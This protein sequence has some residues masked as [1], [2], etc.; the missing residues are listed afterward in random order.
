MRK[1]WSVI[2][3]G[4]V[5][6]KAEE[7]M[8]ATWAIRSA[9][10]RLYP[11]V[12]LAS[13]FF[14]PFMERNGVN[15][16]I[17]NRACP[18]EL[19]DLV[20]KGSFSAGEKELLFGIAKRFEGTP[21]AVRS[22][23]QGDSRGTGIYESVF[24][25]NAAKSMEKG[26][27]PA[28]AK[29]VLASAFSHDAYAFRRDA[30]FGEGMAVMVEPVF[31][32]VVED[33]QYIR[34]IRE[35]EDSPP[36]KLAGKYFSPD[37]S[38]VG[39]T[40]TSSGMGHVTVVG[41]LPTMAVRGLGAMLEEGSN[42][43]LTD[44]FYPSYHDLMYL[45][46]TQTEKNWFRGER[47]DLEMERLAVPDIYPDVPPEGGIGWLF[48]KMKKLER[49]LG[50]PQYIEWA[51]LGRTREAAILQIS[52]VAPKKDFFEFPESGD[53]IIRSKQVTGTNIVTCNRAIWVHDAGSGKLEQ[54][55][56]ENE[57]YLLIYPAILTSGGFEARM[58]GIGTELAYH[59]INNLSAA[60][61]IP[62][63]NAVHDKP[64][65]AHFGGLFDSTGK[66]HMVSSEIS[67]DSL[68]ENSWELDECCTVIEAKFR[69]TASEARQRGIVEII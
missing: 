14:H 69:V 20:Y 52:P 41:G 55:N 39:Y 10:F 59:R 4:S 28:A 42:T 38:G 63:R 18:D 61:E 19:E 50:K 51:A 40:S 35:C 65:A 15:S 53:A 62:S 8:K 16:A 27:I 37:Y 1:Y 66:I 2:G 22:S 47:I 36:D 44:I 30:G 60:V 45:E 68:K 34:F 57:G 11:R 32:R 21:L 24:L 46:F 7:L 12:V 64:P 17:A 31:G 5:G 67:L 6:A 9:G 23:A 48:G 43:A 54:F 58:A 25:T 26:G 3:P 29:I 56:K 33:E 49:L 13:G